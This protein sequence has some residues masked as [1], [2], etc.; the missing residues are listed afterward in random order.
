[1]SGAEETPREGAGAHARGTARWMDGSLTMWC[2]QDQE[3]EKP[4]RI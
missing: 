1:M 4:E 3:Q 2:A